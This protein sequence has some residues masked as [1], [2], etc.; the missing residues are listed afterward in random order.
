MRTEQ[1]K[2]PCESE[3]EESDNLIT[4]TAETGVCVCAM[5]FLVPNQSD[6]CKT[7]KKQMN[8]HWQ[9]KKDKGHH[10]I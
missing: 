1:H 3:A 5:Q 8:V 6:K 4:E 2:K 7:Q 10:S 9:P